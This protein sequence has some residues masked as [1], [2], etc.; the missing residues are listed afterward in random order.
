MSSYDNNQII[1]NFNQ[2]YENDENFYFLTENNNDY[3]NNNESQQYFEHFVDTNVPVVVAA[4]TV[5]NKTK[6]I[7]KHRSRRWLHIFIFVIILALVM[8]YL[9]DN[10]YME[11]PSFLSSSRMTSSA[12][13]NT[14]NAIAS[15]TKNIPGTN[16]FYIN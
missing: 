5:E 14:V 11:M 8:Y 15:T 1:E 12:T 2:G 13:S 6:P 10:K 3:E 4:P 7:K 16:L 9:I